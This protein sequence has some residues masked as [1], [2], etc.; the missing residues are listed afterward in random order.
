MLFG[1]VL[2]SIL[3][4]FLT[5]YALGRRIGS[6]EGFQQGLTYGSLKMRE[7][8][9]LYGKCPLCSKEN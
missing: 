9:Y 8:T 4:I 7:D 1:N 6:R 5:G 3:A 2:I